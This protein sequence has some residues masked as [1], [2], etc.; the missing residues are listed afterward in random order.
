MADHDLP[1][2]GIRVLDV[3]SFIAAPAAGTILSDFGAEVI[4][5]EVP[6]EGDPY[7]HVQRMSVMPQAELN[8]AWLVDNRNKK[9]LCLDL[10][11]PEGREILREM[12][13]TADVF[14]T[15]FPPAVRERLNLRWADL[16]D[17]NP[18]LIYA[19]MTGYGEVGDECNKPGYDAT[20][21]W[22]RSGMMDL[23]RGAGSPP[24]LSAAGM[25]D[26]PTATALYAGIMT[27]L[28]RREKTGRGGMVHT[29][30]MANGAW[31][32]SCL[33]Q[34][35]LV[36]GTFAPPIDRRTCSSPLINTYGC[37]DGRW[38]FLA[39]VQE[40]KDWPRFVAAIER[41]D[42]GQDPRF[43]TRADRAANN[44]ALIALLDAHFL[45][46]DWADWRAGLDANGVTFGAIANVQDVPDD[47]QMAANGVSREMNDARLGRLR[48]VDSPVHLDGV[49]KVTPRRAPDLGEH[50]EEV[51]LAAGFDAARIAV[52]K[53]QGIVH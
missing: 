49:D 12:V 18:R 33:L 8:Y 21:W 32:N 47:P 36:G 5:V 24:A 27:A 11:H 23:V 30:L 9:G 48:V 34:A 42:L 37:R 50:T 43:A 35:A 16:E 22:A 20:A 2:A 6:G 46:R 13:R 7:R 52:W 31:S 17:L 45:T 25:G 53:Q 10:K 40:D 41:P 39:M 38:F 26:H 1:L 29:S 3:G 19:S 14:I 28:Y 4:K 15:N 44:V 51:L